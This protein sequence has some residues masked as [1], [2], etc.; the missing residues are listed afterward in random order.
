VRGLVAQFGVTVPMVLYWV[1]RGLISP[2]QSR[3]PRRG[4]SRHAFWFEMTPPLEAL[5]AQARSQGY[6]PGRR[7]E[8]LGRPRPPPRLPDGRYSTRGLVEKYGVTVNTV[9]YWI[10]K[11]ILSPER[12]LPRG[13]FCFRLTAAIKQRIQ[14]ALSRGR[15]SRSRKQHHPHRVHSH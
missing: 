15:N 5:L 1:R 14:V 7:P 11:G 9:R 10:K 8:H 12:E 6:K 2:V 3:T 4:W 13:Q